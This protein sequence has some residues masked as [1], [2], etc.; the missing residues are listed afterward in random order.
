MQNKRILIL[1]TGLALLVTAIGGA[2]LAAVPPNQTSAVTF[3]TPEDAIT[4][5]FKGVTQGDFSQILQASAMNE[6]SE[7]FRFDLSIERLRAFLPFENYAPADYAFYVELNRAQIA[8]SIARQVKILAYSLLSTQDIDY[9]RVTQMDL[10][11]AVS[12][13][14]EV[15]PAR[16][17][18][19]EVRDIRPPNPAILSS[20]RYKENAVKIARVYGADDST[21]RVVLFAFEDHDYMLGFTLLSYGENWKI[22]SASSPIANTSALGNP[23]KTTIEEFESMTQ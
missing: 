17:A 5:Y 12:F 10:D 3:S 9:S 4:A 6:I 14:A 7:R 21:E 1:I 2:A 20:D 16:L 15:D 18:Q 19:L 22:I 11:T 23:V 8:S 13:M